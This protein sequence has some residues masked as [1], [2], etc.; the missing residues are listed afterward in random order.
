[1]NQKG[2]KIFSYFSP[3]LSQTSPSKDGKE[4]K[5]NPKAEFQYSDQKPITGNP[6]LLN[7]SAYFCREK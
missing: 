2:L 7:R 6:F 3:S 1:M 5:E 4:R